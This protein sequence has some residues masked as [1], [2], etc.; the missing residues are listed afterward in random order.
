MDKGKSIQTEP[1]K[2]EMIDIWKQHGKH[3]Y[4]LLFPS[5]T[6]QLE[7]VAKSYE[8]VFACKPS[9]ERRMEKGDKKITLKV[10]PQE[11]RI[12][13]VLSFSSIFD[14]SIC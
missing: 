11:Y 3:L 1:T 9:L 14:L 7:N 4:D 8:E 12:A 5:E 6:P 10:H 2:E 13:R